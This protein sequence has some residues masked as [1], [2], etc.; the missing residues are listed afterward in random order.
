M[1]SPPEQRASPL[2][3]PSAEDVRAA[4]RLSEAVLDQLGQAILGR[5]NQLRTVLV[6]LL[7]GGHVLVEDVPGTGKTL[8]A[9]TFGTCLDIPLRRIQFNTDLLPSDLLGA[10][11]FDRLTGESQFHP[12]PL[13]GAHLVLADDINRARP[14]TQAALLEAMDEGQVSVEGHTYALSSPFMILATQNPA[15]QEGTHPLPPTQLDR[16]MVRASLGYP[17]FESELALLDRMQDPEPAP[18]PLTVM[19]LDDWRSIQ[20]T[21]RRIHQSRAL[22]LYIA[23]LS[24]HLRE[25][26]LVSLGPSPRASQHLAR[27][28]QAHAAL[29]GRSYVLPDDVKGMAVPVL[30]HRLTLAPGGLLHEIAVDAI[31]EETLTKVPIPW[32]APEPT[33]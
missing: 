15:E 14:T 5:P 11:V 17:P 32:A 31:L 23:S 7:A 16:F 22:R 9:Q 28:A 30:A 6:G 19:G 29:E 13:A 1:N 10:S 4:S 21:V 25:H 33:A 12:G 18:P 3:I 24:N 2:P 20:S 27:A 26:P 8:L